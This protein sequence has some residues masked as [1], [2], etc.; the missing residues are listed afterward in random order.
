[1]LEIAVRNQ[2]EPLAEVGLHV[3]RC[4]G[5]NLRRGGL[6]VGVGAHRQGQLLQDQGG[7]EAA[8]AEGYTGGH[9]RRRRGSPAPS[10]GQVAPQAAQ[11]QRARHPDEDLLQAAHG[12]GQAPGVGDS[13]RSGPLRGSL[14]IRTKEDLHRCRLLGKGALGLG[15]QGA[16][17]AGGG[18]ERKLGVHLALHRQVDHAGG[19][20]GAGV[21]RRQCMQYQQSGGHLVH[22]SSLQSY[23]HPSNT[24][25]KPYSVRWP[26][27][28]PCSR[29][30]A[31]RCVL[32]AS[33]K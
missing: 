16:L 12:E 21:Q 32:S 24:C 25:P 31:S 30:T 7:I 8:G 6:P 10:Q 17:Q 15:A 3:G 13:H 2:D 9:R 11:H 4:Q 1:M 29:S 27:C 20:A 26:I 18:D 22:D 5:G 19:L 33:Q 23:Q 28:A 14:C